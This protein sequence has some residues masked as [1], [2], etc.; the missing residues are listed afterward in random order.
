M[1]TT[2]SIKRSKWIEEWSNIV[3][4]TAKKLLEQK[5]LLKAIASSSWSIFFLAV[6][7]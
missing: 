2:L 6:T 5:T 1:V 3:Q 7:F 4:L